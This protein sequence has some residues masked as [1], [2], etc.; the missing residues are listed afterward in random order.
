M[1]SAAAELGEELARRADAID[2]VADAMSGAAALQ[3]SAGVCWREGA[4][5]FRLAGSDC[6]P[7]LQRLLTANVEALTAGASRPALLLDNKGRVQALMDLGA[8]SD[9]MLAVGEAAATTAAMETLGRYVLASDVA[10]SSV[11]AAILEVI[12]PAAEGVV[13]TA[14]VPESTTLA[15]PRGV[16]ILAAKPVAVWDRL[17]AAGAVPVPRAAREFWR[18]MRCEPAHDTEITGAEFPQELG[19]AGAVDFDKGCYLGQETVARIHYRGQVNRVLCRLRA[20]TTVEVGAALSYQGKVV[21][22]VSSVAAAEGAECVALALLGRTAAAPGIEVTTP[23]GARL[24]VAA[25]V[26]EP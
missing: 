25:T 4:V 26:E 13:A 2:P 1:T 8:S 14:A 9:G 22:T 17:V 18:I 24:T 10:I 23:A 7:F 6:T 5:A 19:L 20:A 16:L 21:G 11:D 3:Q 15:T 12:G